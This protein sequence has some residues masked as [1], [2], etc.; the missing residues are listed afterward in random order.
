MRGKGNGFLQSLCV[1]PSLPG[2]GEI[3]HLSA[4]RVTH[5]FLGM[6][7][8]RRKM[9]R[10]HGCAQYFSNFPGNQWTPL[11]MGTSFSPSE[12]SHTQYEDRLFFISLCFMRSPKCLKSRCCLHGNARQLS[13]F[14]IH[15]QPGAPGREYITIQ[16]DMSM[17]LCACVYVPALMY[18][19][20]HCVFNIIDQAKINP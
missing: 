12:L 4:H 15:L 11:K 14:R 8:W 3:Y 2:G 1:L 6:W 16:N 19:E 13:Q 18:A 10:K 17:C 9:V 7:G 5:L 20:V